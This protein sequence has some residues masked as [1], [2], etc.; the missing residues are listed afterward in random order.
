MPLLMIGTLEWA[1]LRGAVRRHAAE[2]PKPRKPN[3]LAIEALDAR[4]HALVAAVRREL[5]QRAGVSDSDWSIGVAILDWGP[6]CDS[7]PPERVWTHAYAYAR[8]VLRY[9]QPG[10]GAARDLIWE[11]IVLFGCGA[12]GASDASGA[13]DPWVGR[14]EPAV[15]LVTNFLVRSALAAIDKLLTLGALAWSEPLAHEARTDIKET[16][17]QQVAALVVD[18]DCTCGQSRDVQDRPWRAREAHK[19]ETERSAKT[20]AGYHEETQKRQTHCQRVHAVAAWRLGPNLRLDDLVRHA[21]AGAPSPGGGIAAR[22]FRNSALFRY[23]R[24]DAGSVYPIEAGVP[25]GEWRCAAGHPT[26]MRRASCREC[27]EL[28]DEATHLVFSDD[29]K[30]LVVNWGHYRP[31]VFWKC[32]ACETL[33]AVRHEHCPRCAGASPPKQRKNMWVR[34]VWDNLPDRRPGRLLQRSTTSEAEDQMIAQEQ[35]AEWARATG[36]TPEEWLD[37]LEAN[38]ARMLELRNSPYFLR[39]LQAGED[40]G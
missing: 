32:R 12:G 17:A 23:L 21:V 24:H 11:P 5:G 29:R 8:D 40:R 19:P 18:G 20:L 14:W 10:A 22:E 35:D 27:A 6:D 3:E 7:G 16:W 28:F 34:F 15:F 9:R 38:P 2:F 13:G 1:E 4:H 37:E 31:E 25:Y 39:R 33:V 36:K 30:T 26:Y